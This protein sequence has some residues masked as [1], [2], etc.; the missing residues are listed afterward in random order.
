MYVNVGHKDLPRIEQIS[1]NTMKDMKL[2]NK[3][4]SKSLTIHQKSILKLCH[5]ILNHTN[6]DN[7]IMF[8]NKL[9]ILFLVKHNVVPEHIGEPQKYLYIN[10]YFIKFIMKFIEQLF[11]TYHNIGNLSTSS[12]LEGLDE[13]IRKEIGTFE[14][15]V[16]DFERICIQHKMRKS[17]LYCH[18]MKANQKQ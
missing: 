2:E 11:E 13:K 8:V 5:D 12:T 9:M 17:R 3:D 16:D 7:S 14:Q 10:K 1:T 15:N 6:A 18:L 4:I